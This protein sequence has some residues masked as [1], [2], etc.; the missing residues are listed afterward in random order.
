MNK[1]MIR[2]HHVE[3][4]NGNSN[5]YFHEFVDLCL[6]LND[7]ALSCVKC[8]TKKLVL[9][10][11]F[12]QQLHSRRFTKMLLGYQTQMTDRLFHD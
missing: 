10:S 9:L 12:S 5:N 3:A 7:C 2:Q 1:Q 6:Q 11:L 8:F 4:E